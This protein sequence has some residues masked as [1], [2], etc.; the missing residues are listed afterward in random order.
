[1]S[2][3]R[4]LAAVLAVSLIAASAPANP[5]LLGIVTQANDANLGTGPVSEGANVYDGDRLST[6]EDGALTFRARSTIL[7]LARNSR[8]RVTSLPNNLTGTQANLNAGTLVFTATDSATFQISADT[9]TIRPA[10]DTKTIGQIT[11]IDPKTLYIYARQGAI[12]FFYEDETEL[13]PEGKSYKVILDPPDDTPS[14]PGDPQPDPP[15]NHR[16][17]RGFLFILLGVGAAIGSIIK[18]FDDVESPDHP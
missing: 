1:M 15:Q 3:R 7:Y 18:K 11:V 10:T 12:S 6:D 9:A 13:I 14:K 4:L 8:M 16:H 17:H 5:K 2:S